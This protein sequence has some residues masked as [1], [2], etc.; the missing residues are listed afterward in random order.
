M[1]WDS[2]L[3]TTDAS[4]KALDTLLDR[5]R[6]RKIPVVLGDIPELLPGRQ[7]SRPSLNKAIYEK[8]KVSSD[9]YVLRLDELHRQ[10]VREGHLEIKGKRYTLRD[11]VPDGLHLV[12]VAGEFLADRIFALPLFQR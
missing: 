10:V 12:T 7:V 1:F 3:P 2:V 9:C 6:Q 11:L 4:L 8:C 5:A